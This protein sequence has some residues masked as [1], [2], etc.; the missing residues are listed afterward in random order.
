MRDAVCVHLRRT[1]RLRL[2]VLY[3]GL[4]FACGAGLV[5]IAYLLVRHFSG[6][7]QQLTRHG[8]I[9]SRRSAVGPSVRLP[10]LPSLARLQ[11]R[12]Q[13]ALISQHSH[14]LHELLVWSLVALAVMTA[15]AIAVGWLVAGRVLAP[16]RTMTSTTRRISQDNLHQRLALSGPRDELRELGDTIDGLLTRLEAAFASQRRFWPT[17]HTSYAPRWHES[18]LRWTLRSASPARYHHRSWHWTTKSARDWTA[19]SSSWTG[20]WSLGGPSMA[21]CPAAPRSRWIR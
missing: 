21:T 2:T 10:P 4:F 18:A 19:P 1:V 13:A 11:V 5:G 20:S 6:H 14:D 12:A 9:G 17:P 8:P 3:G 16:L 15:V 7:V